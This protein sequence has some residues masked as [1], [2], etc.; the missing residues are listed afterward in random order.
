MRLLL[1]ILWYSLNIV[2]AK[3][4]IAKGLTQLHTIL[5]RISTLFKNVFYNVIYHEFVERLDP[6]IP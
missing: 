5:S 4:R 1:Q 2:N 6:K 3:E